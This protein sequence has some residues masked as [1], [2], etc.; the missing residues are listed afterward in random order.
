MILKTADGQNYHTVGVQRVGVELTQVNSLLWGVQLD[1]LVPLTATVEVFLI[2][3]GSVIDF[4]E[5]PSLE[6]RDRTSEI[7]AGACAVL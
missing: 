7:R 5:I 3:L 2:W 1:H 4:I 6:F